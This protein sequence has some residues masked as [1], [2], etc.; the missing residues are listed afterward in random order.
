MLTDIDCILAGFPCNDCS[1]ENLQRPGLESGMSTRHVSHVF[2]LLEGQRVPWVVLENVVGLLKWHGSGTDAEQ[3]PAIDYIVSELENLG[4]RWAHRVVDLL[5]FGLPHKRRRVFIVASLHGDPR[6]VLL[7]QNAMCQG[8]CV[9]IGTQSECYDCFVTPPRV[10]TKVF[11]ASIDL[12]EKRRA[13]CCDIMHCFTTS[14]GRRTCVATKKGNKGK[15]ELNML[16]IE[17]A[18]RLMGFPCGYT[19]P[20]FPLVAPNQRHPVFDREQQTFRRFALLGL[21]C[22]VPQSHW[23]GEQLK[24]PYSVKFSYDALSLQFENP[25][26]GPATRDRG[27]KAWPLAAYNMLFVNGAPKWTGR[28]RAPSDMSEFPLIR[29]FTPLGDFLEFT[30]NKPVRYELRAGFLRRLELRH[31]NIDSTILEAL[32]VK[33]VDGEIVSV[34]QSQSKKP[35][36]DILE[37]VDDYDE[38]AVNEYFSDSGSSSDTEEDA[39]A[40]LT[41]EEKEKRK[42]DEDGEHDLD[43]DG[44][45]THG[46]AV[47]VD[48]QVSVRGKKMFYPGVALHPLDDHA[49]IPESARTGG[50]ASKVSDDEHRLVVFFDDKHSFAWVKKSKVYPFCTFYA[51]AMKQPM[52]TARS[53][54]TRMID[55]ARRWTNARNL[56]RPQNPVVQRNNQRL[57]TDPTPCGKCNVCVAETVVNE[58]SVPKRKTRNS[59]VTDMKLSVG[60]KRQSKCLQLKVI[61]LARQGQIGATLT[62]RKERALGQRLVVLWERDNAFFAGTLTDFDP[63]KFSFRIDYDDGDVDVDFKPWA[64]SVALAQD[65]PKPADVDVALELKRTNARKAVCAKNARNRVDGS[66]VESPLDGK[67]M[68]R[69]DNGVA[70]QLK[71]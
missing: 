38:Q 44:M 63:H 64:E 10:P 7:S 70:V 49:V 15:A 13:P 66:A 48:W 46:Q 39:L 61:E 69:D 34:G 3:R 33:R 32:D 22:S 59:L 57:F 51:E 21:A 41:E 1:C 35:K 53:T 18:E 40:G 12:G 29:G 8:E 20:C 67:T 54:F 55:R 42:K 9:Q 4:Y 17:D 28:M 56:E 14:N 62:L 25:C 36:Y 50:F 60:S 47:W 5:S 26:P 24:R 27:S 58:S 37:G 30:T 45:T 52:F 65:V 11:A 23:L 19:E 43:E 68:R 16:A 2:R 6:D 71:R 31:E